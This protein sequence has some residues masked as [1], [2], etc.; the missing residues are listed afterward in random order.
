MK[1]LRKFVGIGAIA[2]MAVSIPL[3]SG[4]PVWAEIQEASQSMIENLQ[5]QPEVKLQLAAEKRVVEVDD[6]GQS[7]ET[8]QSL[9]GEQVVV[10]PG[11][12]LRYTLTGENESDRPIQNLVVTQPIPAQTT[13]VLNSATV[14][15]REGATLTYSIDGGQTFVAQPMV[16]V[17]LPDGTVEL[18]PAPAEV[19]THVRWNFGES[20]EPDMA[21][22]ASYDVE[23]R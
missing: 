21:L 12:L 19:Y 20:V 17:T 14:A 8:W 18:Q 1:N 16:E 6:Q 5:R 23:V 11:D 3:L 2:A 13:L 15:D 22:N 7:Q 4:S 9:S 10:Q